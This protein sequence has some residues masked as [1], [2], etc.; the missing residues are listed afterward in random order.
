MSENAALPTALAAELRQ[1]I[2]FPL[3]ERLLAHRKAYLLEG[4]SS[5]KEFADVQRIWGQLEEVRW[6]RQLERLVDSVLKP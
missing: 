2:N 6:L 4:L 3:L 5:P 1:S